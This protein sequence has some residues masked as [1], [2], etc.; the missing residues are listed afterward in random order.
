MQ[1]I[2]I[3]LPIIFQ[4][5][6]LTE[7]FSWEDKMRINIENNYEFVKMVKMVILF[8]GIVKY[9]LQFALEGVKTFAESIKKVNKFI[10]GKYWETFFFTSIASLHKST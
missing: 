10:S 9:C 2:S 7:E 1:K 6:S 8:A 5:L 4:I 3:N